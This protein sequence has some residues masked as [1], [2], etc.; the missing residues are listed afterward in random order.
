MEMAMAKLNAIKMFKV[1]D[2]KK[3]FKLLI[4]LLFKFKFYL[5]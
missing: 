5:F 4:S 2:K 1:L 3:L